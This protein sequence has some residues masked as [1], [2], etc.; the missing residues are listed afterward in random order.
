MPEWLLVLTAGLTTFRMTRLVTKDEF[1]PVRWLR[2]K[3]V[4]WS[5]KKA[6]REWAGDLATCHWCASGWIALGCILLAYFA[7]SFA[8]WFFIFGSVWAVGAGIAHVE[9]LKG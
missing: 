3:I 2:N 9:N 6:S 4:I 8:V 1:P 5:E 7:Y